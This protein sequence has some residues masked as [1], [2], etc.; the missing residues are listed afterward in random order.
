MDHPVWFRRARCGDCGDEYKY[1]AVVHNTFANGTIQ[2]PVSAIAVYTG[3]ANVI[4]NI[5]TNYARGIE[6]LFGGTTFENFNLFFHNAFDTTGGVA[7]G[8]NSTIG[9]P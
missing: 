3:I 8:G 9:D 6:R 4:N 2:N 5:I 7:N 1:H